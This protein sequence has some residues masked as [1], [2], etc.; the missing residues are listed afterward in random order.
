METVHPAGVVV[1][2]VRDQG[3][4]YRTD[5]SDTLQVFLVVVAW[6]DD[7]TLDAA[8]SMQNPSVRTVQRH[9]ARV[10]LEQDRSDVGDAAKLRVGGMDRRHQRTSTI[11][12]TSTGEPRGSSATPTAERAWIPAS[13]STSPR[14]SDAPLITPG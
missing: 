3:Q 7:N 2:P 6:I 10:V 13:P 9:H 11:S 8:R 12:S 4:R 14:N 1:V 5:T